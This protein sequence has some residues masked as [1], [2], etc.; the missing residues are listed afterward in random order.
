MLYPPP[1]EDFL[2]LTPVRD[3]VN[4]M[5]AL[6]KLRKLNYL[7]RNWFCDL[8]ACNIVLQQTMLPHIPGIFLGVRGVKCGWYIQIMTIH[9][10]VLLCRVKECSLLGCFPR[11]NNHRCTVSFLAGTGGDH[12]VGPYILPEIHC[13]WQFLELFASFCVMLCRF[14]KICQ[15]WILQRNCFST[16][17]ISVPKSTTFLAIFSVHQSMHFQAIACM[18]GQSQHF[19][20]ATITQI[21]V[22]PFIGM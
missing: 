19:W 9:S 11:G 20:A 14:G 12:F 3:W 10:T 22:I 6:G 4:P 2:V 13:Y 21:I 16:F 5:D 18:T 17:K 8:P 1:Q 7:I 15:C